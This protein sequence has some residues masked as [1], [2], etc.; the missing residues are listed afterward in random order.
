M[1]K[2]KIKYLKDYLDLKHL[3]LLYFALVHAQLTYGIVAWGG[4]SDTQLKKLSVFQRWILRVIYRKPL[5]RSNDKLYKDSEI[6]DV[7]TLLF[8]YTG[9]HK[10]T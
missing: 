4:V 7:R 2:S 6:L 9:E 8:K 10:E 1:K 5:T 3:R